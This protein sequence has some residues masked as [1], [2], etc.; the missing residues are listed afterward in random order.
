MT[1][2]LDFSGQVL[3][4]EAVP[5]AESGADLAHKVY[6]KFFKT[7]T[8]SVANN[9]LTLKLGKNPV[10]IEGVSERFKVANR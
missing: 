3:V 9:Q 4:T 8:Q 5:D 6:P 2:E 7:Q 10:F 1:L